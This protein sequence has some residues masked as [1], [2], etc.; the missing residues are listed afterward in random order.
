MR[1]RNTFNKNKKQHD[2]SQDTKPKK[3][4]SFNVPVT[5]QDEKLESSLNILAAHRTLS[6]NTA[7]VSLVRAKLSNQKQ[8]TTVLNLYIENFA[9]VQE[10][11]VQ[12]AKNYKA[13]NA[14][15]KYKIAAEE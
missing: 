4:F 12:R 2:K 11:V 7:K 15:H 6:S 14:C 9:P 1:K 5:F 3:T 13:K 10:Y 8:R